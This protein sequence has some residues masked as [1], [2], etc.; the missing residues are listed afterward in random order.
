MKTLLT[1]FLVCL[2]FLVSG[3]DKIY[4]KD[5][6]VIDC[7]ITE[8]G[9]T[10]IKYYL[11]PEEVRNSPVI[12]IAVDQVQKVVLGSG[13][14]IVFNDPLKDEKLY[15]E[16]KKRAIKIHFLSPLLEHLAFSYEKNLKPGRSIEH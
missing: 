9:L 11:S 3:Q 16:D 4:K 8:V 15:A 7:I 6:S 10:E 1:S 14:E 5:Q 12:S 13:R 2:C